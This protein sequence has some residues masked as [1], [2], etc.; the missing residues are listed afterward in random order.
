MTALFGKPSLRRKEAGAELWQFA[1]PACVM[2][3]YFYQDGE[4][5][6]VSY[7]SLRDPASGRVGGNACQER[8]SKAL[9]D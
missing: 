7:V 8:L 9:R 2:D 4:V 1:D 5:K 6:R 3:F